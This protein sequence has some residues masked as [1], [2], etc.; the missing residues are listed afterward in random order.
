MPGTLTVACKIPT[1]LTLQ[2]FRMEEHVEPLFGG[3]QKKVMRA[4]RTHEPPVTIKGPAR[5]AGKDLPHDIKGGC[6]LTYGVDADFFNRWLEQNKDEPYV[7][8]GMIFA[9]ASG[10]PTEIDA[11]INDH[12]KLRSGL[13]PLNPSDL[14]REFKGKIEQADAQ[15]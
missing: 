9:Q 15:Q 4:V 3:G 5:Y 7:K 10:K 14:P 1:G 13:E 2:L 8:N 6:G 12:I 11:Q